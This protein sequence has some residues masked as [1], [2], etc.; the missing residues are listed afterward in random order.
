LT[1]HPPYGAPGPFHFIVLPATGCLHHHC[2]VFGGHHLVFSGLG[3][4]HY[5][6][7]LISANKRFKFVPEEN[8]SQGKLSFEE[9]SSPENPRGKSAHIKLCSFNHTNQ[10]TIIYH[11][12]GSR[13]KKWPRNAISLPPLVNRLKV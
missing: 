6:K 8:L 5:A 4:R 12:P 11:R 9:N 2:W 7:G 13:S 1:E 3:L 10:C